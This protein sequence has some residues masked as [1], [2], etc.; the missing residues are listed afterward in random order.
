MSASRIGGFQPPEK[1]TG[2]SGAFIIVLL[3]HVAAAVGSFASIKPSNAPHPAAKS[4]R[5][6]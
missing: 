1:K 6:V 5:S 4:R 2:L 3:I